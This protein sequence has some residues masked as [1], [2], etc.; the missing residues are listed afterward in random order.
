MNNNEINKVVEVRQEDSESQ[1]NK[2][3][4]QGWILLAAV[5]QS[6]VDGNQGTRATILYSVGRIG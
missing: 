2:L 3:L 1:V 5:G 6:S 4:N